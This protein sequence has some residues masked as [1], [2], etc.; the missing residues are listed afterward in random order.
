MPAHALLWR[1]IWPRNRQALA[2][3]AAKHATPREGLE[4]RRGRRGDGVPRNGERGRGLLRRLDLLPVLARGG[5]THLADHGQRLKA[6]SS[7]TL[8]FRPA[9]AFSVEALAALYTQTFVGYAYA[10]TVSAADLAGFC[11]IEQLDLFHSPA[12][13]DV[14]EPVGHASLSLRAARASSQA[15]GITP[16]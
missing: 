16:A 3:F 10:S 6:L 1:R 13:C 5:R 11:R 15:F 14:A 2:R 9:A 12:L 4:P 7:V 8:H